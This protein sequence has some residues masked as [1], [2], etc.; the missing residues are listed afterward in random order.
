MWIDIHAHAK[1]TDICCCLKYGSSKF[2]SFEGIS[3]TND[4]YHHEIYAVLP[5]G[6]WLSIIGLWLLVRLVVDEGQ[7]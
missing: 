5:W 4:V 2:G 7:T 3:N 1:D 6:L